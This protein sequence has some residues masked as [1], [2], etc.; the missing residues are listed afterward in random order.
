MLNTS[1]LDLNTFGVSK[2]VLYHFF[3]K[4][5]NWPPHVVDRLPLSQIRAELIMAGVKK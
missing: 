3:A 1:S 4:T 2:L 5:R